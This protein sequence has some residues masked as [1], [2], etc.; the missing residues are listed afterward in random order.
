MVYIMQKH[1]NFGVMHDDVTPDGRTPLVREVAAKSRNVCCMYV[2][3]EQEIPDGGWE[4]KKLRI[5]REI[6]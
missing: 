6:S 1:R 4:A 3:G 2:Q 5:V